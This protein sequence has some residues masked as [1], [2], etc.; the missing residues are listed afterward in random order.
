MTLPRGLW[1]GCLSE[2]SGPS[3]KE[4][5]A[6]EVTTSR[7][8]R[9]SKCAYMQSGEEISRAVAW[10]TTKILLP[11][12][13][14]DW[15]LSCVEATFWEKQGDDQKLPSQDCETYYYYFNGSSMLY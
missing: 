10:A 14:Y 15:A 4:Q 1:E 11:G 5:R 13:G 12:A 3:Q 9:G 7:S 2:V 6:S 8:H